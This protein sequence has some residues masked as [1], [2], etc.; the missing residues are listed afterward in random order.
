MSAYRF[1]LFVSIYSTINTFILC[2]SVQT[3]N[4]KREEDEVM[5]IEPRRGS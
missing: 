3:E 4:E 1:S 5:L 2:L